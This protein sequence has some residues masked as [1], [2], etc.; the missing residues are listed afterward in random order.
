MAV[1]VG[2]FKGKLTTKGSHDKTG[3][4]VEES[5]ILS[6]SLRDQQETNA[7]EE[8]TALTRISG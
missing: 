5:W 8:V 2:C 4:E 6:P 3:C 1:C 7:P